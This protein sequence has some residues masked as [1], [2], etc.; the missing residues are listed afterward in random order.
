[1]RASARCESLWR[2]RAQNP[3]FQCMAYRF[4]SL[5]SSLGAGLVAAVL[6]TTPAALAQGSQTVSQPFQ[7]SNPDSAMRMGA[8]DQA[9]DLY[10]PLCEA[11]DGRACYQVAEIHRRGL[12]R[13]QDFDAADTA[14]QAACDAGFAS[15]CTQLGNLLFE[16]RGVDEDKPRARALYEIAC[17][18]GEMAACG[19]LGSMKYVGLGGPRERLEGETLMRRSCTAG[20]TYA[21]SQIERYGIRNGA[22]RTF[23]PW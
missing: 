7:H 6:V 21:C 18:R 22:P 1:M 8:F 5:F 9:F 16:G 19:A 4:L 3:R 20:V 2:G 23:S 13:A 17:E 15:G 12:D 10:T 11:G 14:Y